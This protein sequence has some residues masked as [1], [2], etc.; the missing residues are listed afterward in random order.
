MEVVGDSVEGQDDQEEAEHPLQARNVRAPDLRQERRIDVRELFVGNEPVLAV[1]EAVR[2][3]ETFLLEDVV[4]LALVLYGIADILV[5]LK[6]ARRHRDRVVAGGNSNFIKL[7]ILLQSFVFRRYEGVE[8]NEIVVYA[9][10]VD[11]RRD[12]LRGGAE[13]QE[14]ERQEDE[15]LLRRRVTQKAPDVAYVKAALILIFSIKIFVAVTHFPSSI[16]AL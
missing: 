2:P 9:L 8:R 14:K 5:L 11:V 7:G 10:P 13:R 4:V 15:E 12:E 3:V 1:N 16:T 6:E